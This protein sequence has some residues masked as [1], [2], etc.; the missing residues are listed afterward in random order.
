[1]YSFRKPNINIF[2]TKTNFS[3][4]SS[5]VQDRTGHRQDRDMDR[6]RDTGRSLERDTNMDRDISTQ[7][8][9]GIVVN[10]K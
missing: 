1:L 2:D 8:S 4:K 10:K 7:N 6:D 9:G 5:K 3:Q